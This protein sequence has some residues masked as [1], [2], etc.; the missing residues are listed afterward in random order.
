[1]RPP[2]ARKPRR[3]PKGRRRCARA[4]PRPLID[5]IVDALRDRGITD[6]QIHS[7]IALLGAQT[8]WNVHIGPML[9][10]IEAGIAT[11]A[12]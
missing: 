2:P 12:R 1:M 11:Y 6:Y 10:E 5:A 7:Y 8:F 3:P 4:T 9:D